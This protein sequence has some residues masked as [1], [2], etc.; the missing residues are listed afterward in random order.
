MLSLDHIA[1][2]YSLVAL[3]VPMGDRPPCN[4]INLMEAEGL[5]EL[6][7]LIKWCWKKDPS[8]RPTF[9]GRHIL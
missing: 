3:K 9:K 1:A 2:A 8:D 6:V 7:N 4:E 5:K